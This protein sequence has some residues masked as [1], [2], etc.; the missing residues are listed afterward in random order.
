M[1]V[2]WDEVEGAM[3]ADSNEGVS[4][5]SSNEDGVKRQHSAN[6]LTA[7]VKPEHH[8]DQNDFTKMILSHLPKPKFPPLEWV[9]KHTREKTLK[10]L[11]AGL[12]VMVTVRN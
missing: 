7:E 1:P 5:S 12:I 4:R 6:T 9:P 3:R 11:N 2:N 10:D 8:F